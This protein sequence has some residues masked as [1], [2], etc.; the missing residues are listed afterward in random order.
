MIEPDDYV[1]FISDEGKWCRVD[2]VGFVIEMCIPIYESP[3]EATDHEN[4]EVEE[5]E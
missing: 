3:L 5:G 1:Y 4:L 2:R